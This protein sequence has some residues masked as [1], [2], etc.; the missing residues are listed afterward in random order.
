MAAALCPNSQ[1]QLPPAGAHG[2]HRLE[3]EFGTFEELAAPTELGAALREPP[4]EFM[5]QALRAVLQEKCDDIA[6]LG[7]VLEAAFS[8]NTRLSSELRQKET[9][10]HAAADE[11]SQARGEI[12]FLTHLLHVTS[13]SARGSCQASYQALDDLLLGPPQPYAG[14][15]PPHTPREDELIQ[16]P[17]WATPVDTLPVDTQVQWL[18]PAA[19]GDGTQV[20]EPLAAPSE[21]A[22]PAE[23]QADLR[24]P[25]RRSS[26]ELPRVVLDLMPAV[27]LEE[28]EARRLVHNQWASKRILYLN[29]MRRDRRQVAARESAAPRRSNAVEALFIDNIGFWVA[30]YVPR[31]WAPVCSKAARSVVRVLH[32]YRQGWESVRLALGH[33]QSRG[34]AYR[35][36]CDLFGPEPGPLIAASEELKALKGQIVRTPW[37]QMRGGE[38]K[39]NYSLHQW[40]VHIDIIANVWEEMRLKYRQLYVSATV[41]TWD[42]DDVRD[43]LEEA[44]AMHG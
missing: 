25:I 33:W 10:L 17:D 16:V 41:T 11:L 6:E 32:V 44:L 24:A 22:L 13:N 14:F 39:L 4:A 5:V 36:D 42:L 1:H 21:W 9:E 35:P 2:Q 20:R 12:E 15:T 8:Q 31:S 19:Q 7:Q 38:R 27:E 18:L 37:P 28:S 26:D 43:T 30:A 40:C 29:S 23:A 34:T 3:A